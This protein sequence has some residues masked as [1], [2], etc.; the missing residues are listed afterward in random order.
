MSSATPLGGAPEGL[1]EDNLKK[2]SGD[3]AA[4]VMSE[5][6]GIFL[7]NRPIREQEVHIMDLA[8]TALHL[9]GVPVPAQYEGRALTIESGEAQR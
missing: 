3:H 5:T 9:L 4:S 2:W 1:F 8:P 7:S 6:K